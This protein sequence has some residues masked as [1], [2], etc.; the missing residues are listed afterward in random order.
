MKVKKYQVGGQAP[1]SAPQE[2]QADPQEQLAN[3]ANELIQNL[4][5]EAAAMLADM[6]MQMLQGAAQQAPA[7]ARKGTK[8]VRI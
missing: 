2:G 6:I 1:Q 4:G 7:Y 3:I 8:L 5:P